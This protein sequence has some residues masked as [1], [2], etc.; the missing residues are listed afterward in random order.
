MSS[1]IIE[2]LIGFLLD[3][4]SLILQHYNVSDLISIPIGLVGIIFIFLGIYRLSR[5]NRTLQS[6]YTYGS[7]NYLRFQNHILQS[8]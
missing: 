8:K 7:H 5:H 3:A 4:I 1:G 2:F 6:S